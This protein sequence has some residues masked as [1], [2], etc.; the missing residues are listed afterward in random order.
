MFGSDLNAARE[1]TIERSRR[2]SLVFSIPFR[3]RPGKWGVAAVIF[4][5]VL[6]I[7]AYGTGFSYRPAREFAMV[8]PSQPSTNPVEL[9]K[10]LGRLRSQQK[11]LQNA[12][13]QKS[14]RGTY[15]IIDQT[16][17]RLY[18][19]KDGDTIFEAKCSAGS[20][21]VLQEGGGKNRRWIFDTPRGQFKVLQ[22]VQ[23]PV[24]KKPDW[25]FVEEGKPIPSDPDERFEYGTLGEYALHFGNGYMIHGTLYERLLGRSVTHGCIRLG[26]EDLRKVWSAVPLGTPI[27]IY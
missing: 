3:L 10:D 24:W 22:R 15:V 8:L 6:G 2:S 23:N 12:L 9:Q 13:R 17:N 20:G 1:G 7:A 26:K 5:V 18:L 16:L 21:M 19:K 14:P 4:L 27:Y 25:A 11:T